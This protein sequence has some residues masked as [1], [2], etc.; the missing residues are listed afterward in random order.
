MSSPAPANERALRIGSLDTYLKLSPGFY[1]TVRKPGI[2]V[3]EF[4]RP[5]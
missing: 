4:T 2:T 1:N 3:A 5:R